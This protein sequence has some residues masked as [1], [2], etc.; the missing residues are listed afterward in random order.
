MAGQA[1]A[2]LL[3]VLRQGLEIGQ[4]AVAPFEHPLAFR[5]EALE[6]LAAF[7]DGHAEIGL[8]LLDRRR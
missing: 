7:D 8:E 4:D 5:R 2:H 1:L 3:Q 6:A